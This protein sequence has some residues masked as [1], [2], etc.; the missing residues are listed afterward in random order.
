MAHP[1]V[2]ES[3]TRCIGTAGKHGKL[4]ALMA[5]PKHAAE[6]AAKGVDLLFCCSDV[7]ALRHG[8]RAI[9][10]DFRASLT[11]RASV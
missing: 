7:A 11:E 2:V 5:S 8:V 1:I 10:D 9:V 6:W 3:I 4:A